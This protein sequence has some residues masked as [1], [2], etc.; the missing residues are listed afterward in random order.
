MIV[1]RRVRDPGIHALHSAGSCCRHVVVPPR[2]IWQRAA[3]R[4][5]GPP[6]SGFV[7]RNR[8]PAE[9]FAWSVRE[10]NP[11][12]PDFQSGALSTEL[13]VLV[14]LSIAFD[15]FHVRNTR[16][17]PL[18]PCAARRWPSDVKP[19]LVVSFKRRRWES[20]PL[21]AALQAV[22]W[23]SGSSVKQVPSPGIGPGPRPSRGRVRIRHT[24][25]TVESR[26][27]SR[28]SRARIT[29]PIP[30]L[31]LDSRLST[32]QHLAEE[33]NPVLQI[34][35][36]P[37]SSITLARRKQ[38]VQESNLVQQLRR[39]TCCPAHPRAMWSV[40]RPGVEPGPRP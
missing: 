11:R 9:A 30:T 7:G 36:L 26:S 32:I 13:T 39:L 10:S 40:S 35:S 38:P 5:I 3:D 18:I 1:K 27:E 12:Q 23:P 15:R 33:S 37:C 4:A 2:R 28:E 21:Q 16:H 34:R 31:S 20:N 25:R 19:L 22:A 8:A 29:I 24:P 6:P 14:D 17:Q